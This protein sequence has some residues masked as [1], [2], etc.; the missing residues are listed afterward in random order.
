MVPRETPEGSRVLSLCPTLGSQGTGEGAAEAPPEVCTPP[1]AGVL[2]GSASS[3]GSTSGAS[4]QG[5]EALTLTTCFSPGDRDGASKTRSF[6]VLFFKRIHPFQRVPPA[7]PPC[8]P[9]SAQGFSVLLRVDCLLQTLSREA[10][11]GPESFPPPAPRVCS[12]PPRSVPRP[13]GSGCAAH[14]GNLG[15]AGPPG[16]ASFSWSLSFFDTRFSKRN[17]RTDSL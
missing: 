9:D 11:H 14:V 16:A 2:L 5:S 1:D 15:V 13:P 10:R 8:A 6:C 3:W 12:P 7:P 4:N 17:V